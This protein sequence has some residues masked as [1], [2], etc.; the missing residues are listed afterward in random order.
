MFQDSSGARA[1]AKARHAPWKSTEDPTARFRR[2]SAATSSAVGGLAGC[3]LRHKGAWIFT[4]RD[5][6]SVE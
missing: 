1:V 4:G 3:Q 5:E 2:A 6:P